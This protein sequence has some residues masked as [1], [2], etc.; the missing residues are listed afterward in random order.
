MRR[1]P[2]LLDEWK[3]PEMKMLGGMAAPD[4]ISAEYSPPERTYSGLNWLFLVLLE[5]FVFQIPSFLF[6]SGGAMLCLLLL[7]LS[8]SYLSPST[9]SLCDFYFIFFCIFD[10]GSQYAVLAGLECTEILLTERG[11]AVSGSPMVSKSEDGLFII[12]M[13]RCG[14]GSIQQSVSLCGW[15]YQKE[16]WRYP[17][18][19]S[20]YSLGSCCFYKSLSLSLDLKPKWPKVAHILSNCLPGG[21]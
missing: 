20:P 5:G 17:G 12:D 15:R 7:F 19:F 10:S 16:G 6:F 9:R 14:T 11:N 8:H 4:T 1:Y 13:R 21:N 2:Y 18:D 3:N